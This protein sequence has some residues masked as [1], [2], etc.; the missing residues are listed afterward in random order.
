MLYDVE[1]PDGTIEEYSTNI[2][3]EN[4]IT[5][6]DYDGFNMTMIK[7]I[8]DHNKDETTAISKQDMYIITS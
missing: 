5:Q 4:M 6:V 1:F 7:G 8:I 2:I 3:A